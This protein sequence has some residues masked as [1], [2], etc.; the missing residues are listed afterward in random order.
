MGEMTRRTR[1]ARDKIQETTTFWGISPKTTLVL[2]L[3]F[4]CVCV[5]V[6]CVCVCVMLYCVL[7]VVVVCV[8]V[9]AYAVV[10]NFMT[11][12]DRAQREA[13]IITLSPPGYR[14]TANCLYDFNTRMNSNNSD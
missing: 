10:S 5:C 8:C 7:C 2:S 12:S 3:T 1:T 6:L 13:S 11:R 4:R 14:W 9:C